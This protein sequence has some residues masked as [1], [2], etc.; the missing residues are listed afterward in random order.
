MPASTAD[1][2]RRLS[3][4][5][6][7]AEAAAGHASQPLTAGPGARNSRRA[8]TH[9]LGWLQLGLV[10][11][12]SWT[13]L[14]ALAQATK[15]ALHVPTIESDLKIS[16]GRR[17][18]FHDTLIAGLQAGVSSDATVL[19]ADEVRT[20]LAGRA[21]LVN[22]QYGACVAKVA[23]ALE[24]DRLIIPRIGVRDAVGGAA[25]KISLAVYDRS[26]NPL[27]I[28]G[29]DACGNDVEGCVLAKALEAMKRASGSIAAEVSKPAG[30][31]KPAVAA[32][33]S[34]TTST[35]PAMSSSTSAAATSSPTTSS[36]VTPT[37][38]GTTA[39]LPTATDPSASSS[40]KPTPSKYANV[41]HYGWMV[42]AGATAA[43]I[44]TSIP[45]LSFAG[46]DGMTT[47]G[48]DVPVVACP[49][50]YTGNL[51]GGLGLL[52]GGGLLS[53]GTFGVLFYLDRQE[54]K[55][56]K[57]GR[58]VLLPHRLMIGTQGQGLAASLRF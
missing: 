47:C 15:V 50:V 13:A 56:M 36:A 5:S 24:V 39:S 19:R 21:E 53:A 38:T 10:T 51:A 25:Y 55:R 41:Y 12:T 30:A 35:S 54:H 9:S 18:K 7:T 34:P 33:T 1:D 27:P 46:R 37:D 48:P 11:L 26:G 14:P 2:L 17:N 43:F 31:D 6:A 16:E 49:T 4:F 40:D 28:S 42:A 22:C 23:N 32:M 20:R 44:I 3:S 8:K 45:F 52:L 29:S 57:D 58:L